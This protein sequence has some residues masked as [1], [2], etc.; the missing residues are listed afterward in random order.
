MGAQQTLLT[1]DGAQALAHYLRE[2]PEEAH[3]AP[4]DLAGDFGLPRDFVREVLH[5]VRSKPARS[6]GRRSLSLG[7]LMVGARTAQDAL[8]WLTSRP[9]VFIGF[10]TLFVVAYFCFVTPGFIVTETRSMG[11]SL[12]ATAAGMALVP[13]CLVLHW[14]CY[15]RHGMARLAL[16]G[17]LLTWLIAAPAAMVYAWLQPGTA[18]PDLA[19]PMLLAVALTLLMLC[20]TIGGIGVI[21]AVIGGYVRVRRSDRAELQMT[22]QQLLERLFEIQN[23]LKREQSDAATPRRLARVAQSLSAHPFLYGA[24]LGFTTHSLQ[25]LALGYLMVQVRAAPELAPM[26]VAASITVTLIQL[27]AMIAVGFFA[28]SVPKGALAVLW[29]MAWM[30]VAELLP[31]PRPDEIKLDFTDVGSYVSQFG[32]AGVVGLVAGLGAIV[33]GRAAKQVR[34]KANDPAALLAELVRI[35]W[36]LGPSI[37]QVCVLVVDAA[38]SATMKQGA[39]PHAVE[40]SFRE[41]LRLI[42]KIAQ[43]NGGRVHNT[44]GDGAV[45][46]FESCAAALKAGKRLLTEID[47]FNMTVNRLEQPFRLRVG[48]HKGLVTGDIDKVEF[49]QVIDIAAHVQGAAPIGGIAITEDVARDLP[50]E[51]LA[52]LKDPVDGC[53]VFLVLNPLG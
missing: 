1:P 25:V 40:Y 38:K 3:R 16:Q 14:F 50:G 5:A 41:Y 32:L 49:S 19:I 27:L 46:T 44:M 9:L 33:Q 11:G 15:Y 20:F 31:V 8:L 18:K 48:L 45:A 24:V 36:R 37:A 39:D 13:L 10:S 52:E 2:N 17:A 42:E 7:W 51:G 35:Q 29:L 22:R 26:L 6:E 12:K 21:T 43:E 30:F 47:S 23:K 28:G 53:K 34:L 4:E